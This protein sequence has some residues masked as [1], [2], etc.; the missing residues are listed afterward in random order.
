MKMEM[1]KKLNVFQDNS[2][3]VVLKTS[4]AAQLSYLRVRSRALIE[5]NRKLKLAQSFNFKEDLYDA[6]N[7]LLNSVQLRFADL[8]NLGIPIEK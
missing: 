8:L 7:C 4:V 6:K 5:L 3:R 1:E 2:N